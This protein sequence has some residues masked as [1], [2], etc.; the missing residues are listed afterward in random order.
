MP[1]THYLASSALIGKVITIPLRVRNEYW[2]DNNRVLQGTLALSYGFG[3]KFKVGNDPYKP[4]YFSTILYAAGISQQK[5]FSI[6]GKFKKEPSRDSI[7][8]KTDEIAVTY[9]SLGAAYEYD[10][11]NVGVFAGKDRMF[12]N[13]KNWAYQDKW[14]FGLGIGYDLFK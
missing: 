14:W 12:G 13:L 11:F 6:A 1:H 9:W 10:K 4:H 7:S 5:H 8:A 2:N 3:L